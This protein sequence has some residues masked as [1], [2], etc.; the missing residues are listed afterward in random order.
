MATPLPSLIE[1]V[2]DANG[3]KTRLV[4]Q[5]NNQPF[6]LYILGFLKIVSAHVNFFDELQSVLGNMPKKFRAMTMFLYH[7]LGRKTSE[8]RDLTNFQTHDVLA[9]ILMAN[10]AIKCCGDNTCPDHTL[11]SEWLYVIHPYVRLERLL[12][13]INKVVICNRIVIKAVIKTLDNFTGLNNLM[14]L[15]C[16]KGD[17]ELVKLCIE[18]GA[19]DFHTALKVS[20]ISK[21]QAVI[22]LC[23]EYR[24]N[25][26]H[27]SQYFGTAPYDAY[28]VTMK[29]FRP[30][31]CH[32]HPKGLVNIRSFLDMDG[33]LCRLI[34]FS[35]TFEL[36]HCM[37]KWADGIFLDIAITD[38]D[39][40]CGL[41]D[42]NEREWNY[43]RIMYGPYTY[44]DIETSSEEDASSDELS[45]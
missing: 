44:S 14:I 26:S 9:H 17:L 33:C 8:F 23:L 3:I 30:F 22:D 4:P 34:D 29:T 25:S 36:N 20:I 21:N 45:T 13:F 18:E 27:K 40:I 16:A 6:S 31:W 38:L 42:A 35:H 1:I 24:K 19:D 12:P 11:L 10:F 43:L 7:S 37:R 5:I 15:L 2:E 41:M 39:S 32:L 28:Y